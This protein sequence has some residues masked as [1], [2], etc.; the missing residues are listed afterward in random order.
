[1]SKNKIRMSISCAV[2][3]PLL[4]F[5][6]FADSVAEGGEAFINVAPSAP[7]KGK[8]DKGKSITLAPEDPGGSWAG[9]V[10][11]LGP[12]GAVFNLDMT[13][14]EY[15]SINESM[16]TGSPVTLEAPS[17]AQLSVAIVDADATYSPTLSGG[18]SLEGYQ[19]GAFGDDLFVGASDGLYALEAIG[20][21][22]GEDFD[23]SQ[24]EDGEEIQIGKV[25]RGRTT[26][27][28]RARVRKTQRRN[29]SA[30]QIDALRRSLGTL[31]NPS[32]DLLIAANTNASLYTFRP[33]ESG[34][35]V[36]ILFRCARGTDGVLIEGVEV[37]SR[38]KKVLNFSDLAVGAGL[39]VDSGIR[40]VAREGGDVI[41]PLPPANYSQSDTIGVTVSN[42]DG[43][44]SALLSVQM[45]RAADLPAGR[46]ALSA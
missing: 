10:G 17:G 42:S 21:A 37:N 44:N 38:E 1:M 40:A 11:M 12:K 30:A 35:F 7:V 18:S 28:V 6:P 22:E 13:V 16:K 25:R 34:T 23:L 41:V 4:A 31:S 8:S 33:P 43:V 46:D 9:K 36:A 29:R 2:L 32:R 27:V 14:E 26:S 3:S 39:T 19:I 45:L 24:L 20:A 15:A 5:I